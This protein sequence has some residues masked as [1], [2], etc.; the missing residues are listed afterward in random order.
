[1]QGVEIA[2]RLNI[3]FSTLRSW[4]ARRRL[5]FR[6]PS[7]T[8]RLD[9]LTLAAHRQGLKL[10]SAKRKHGDR[11]YLWTL[12][13]DEP[14]TLD[15]VEAMLQKPRGPVRHQNVRRVLTSAQRTL[16]TNSAEDP[17]RGDVSLPSLRF[18]QDEPS[19]AHVGD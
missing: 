5:T 11:F 12:L 18:L 1:V 2:R 8:A 4:A 15:E 6:R 7:P 14:L 9:R 13:V 3:P 17:A 10:T 19:D 16:L